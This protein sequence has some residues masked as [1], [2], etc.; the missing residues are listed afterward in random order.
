MGTVRLDKSE[1]AQQRIT[2]AVT[3]VFE[4]NSD[5]QQALCADSNSRRC[6]LR[7]WDD[8]RSSSNCGNGR[9]W[10]VSLPVFLPPATFDAGGY[11]PT[12]VAI[13][14]LNHDGKADVVVSN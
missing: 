6:L 11:W 12:S 2:H 9:S 1:R 3:P 10:A 14:D 7:S 13:A 8:L 4:R 5:D